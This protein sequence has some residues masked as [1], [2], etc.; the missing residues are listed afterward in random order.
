VLAYNTFV[1][2][3]RLVLARLDAFAHDLYAVLTTG[4]HIGDPTAAVPIK[5]A[6]V[7]TEA[8]RGA[9]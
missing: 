2:S 3:N 4:S 5:R 6:V 8:V 1:R 9:A 7:A